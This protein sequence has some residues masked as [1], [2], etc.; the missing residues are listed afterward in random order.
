[1]RPRKG[2][3]DMDSEPEGWRGRHVAMAFAFGA[4]A[5]AVV[6]LLLAPQSGARTRRKVRDTVRTAR[7][8]LGDLPGTIDASW[9]RAAKA[10]RTALENVLERSEPA[11][12]S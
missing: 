8:S 1:M 7:E 12:H 3:C 9:R 6:A 10:A 2:A 4:L 11:D 5:G